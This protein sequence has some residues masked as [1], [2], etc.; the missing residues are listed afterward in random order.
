VE[1]NDAG[2]TLFF[3]G[4]NKKKPKS[5]FGLPYDILEKPLARRGKIWYY[6]PALGNIIYK[7][8]DFFGECGRFTSLTPRRKLLSRRF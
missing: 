1:C 8:Y 5:L 7:F 2:V 6:D 3:W 4:V